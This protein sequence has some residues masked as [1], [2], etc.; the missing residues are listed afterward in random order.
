M[1]SISRNR[2]VKLVIAFI[3]KQPILLEKA[4]LILKKSFGEI[5]FTSQ[6]LPFDYTDYYRKEMGDGLKRAFIS[7]PKLIP[8]ENLS[9]IKCLTN[10]IEAKF[11][12]HGCRAINID[13]GYLDLARLVL[14][15][16]KDFSHRI[17]LNLGIYAELT[18]VYKDGS[19]RPNPWT[20]P[21]YR[22][23]GYIKIFRQIREIYA[24]QIKNK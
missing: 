24:Q 10:K 5:D 18:L 17:Y 2:P 15:S 7:F 13:P 3:F 20:Y 21:D 23:E 12:D 1:G 22:T 11:S 4:K 9:K 14:A 19:F 6:I 8:P 16:T